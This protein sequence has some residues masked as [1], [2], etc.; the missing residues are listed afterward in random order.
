MFIHLC[1]LYLPDDVI[2]E[3]RPR[4]TPGTSLGGYGTKTVAWEPEVYFIAR[5]RQKALRRG[6]K[7]L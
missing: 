1:Y 6:R 3:A 2:P 5:S 7:N 4:S